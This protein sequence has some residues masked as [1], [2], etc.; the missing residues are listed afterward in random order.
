M[1]GKQRGSVR[2]MGDEE[3]PRSAEEGSQLNIGLHQGTEG[4]PG[5]KKMSK[6][7]AQAAVESTG[8]KV[9]KNTVLTPEK[10]GVAEPTAVIS[11]DRPISDY[12]MQDVLAKT[13]QSAIPQRTGQGDESMHVAPGHEETAKKEGW[14]KFNPDYFREHDGRTASEAKNPPAYDKHTATP[15][16]KNWFG[17]SKVTQPFN[18]D[19]QPLPVFHGTTGDFSKFSAKG[20]NPESDHGK[21][22][23]FSNEPADVEHNYAGKGPDLTQKID[24][25]AERL[26]ND[27]MTSDEAYTRAHQQFMKHGGMTMPVYLRIEN[28][29]II[30]DGAHGAGTEL[31]Q[32][33]LPKFSESLRSVALAAGAGDWDMKYLNKV[34]GELHEHAMDGSIP[35]NEAIKKIHDSEALSDI[36]DD[37]GNTLGREIVR[38]ALQ[39]MGYD[40]IIDHDVNKKFGTEKENNYRTGGMKGMN[41]D[42]VHYIAFKPHQIK[43]AIGNSGAFSRKN[44]DIT[45][46]NESKQSGALA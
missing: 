46:K 41:P 21:G 45:A 3:S 32:R 11:T 20:S 18:S 29:A 39:K 24:L 26:M 14:D 34:L 43:S 6:Q 15:E 30:G 35:L 31:T 25:T 33:T 44:A 8:A 37:K 2:V 28:P 4:Q 13:K 40:G 42:T 1:G 9:T 10:H 22:F 16:F 36:A 17:K 19:K 7:E 38:R 5:F 23:Y 12:K 27:G